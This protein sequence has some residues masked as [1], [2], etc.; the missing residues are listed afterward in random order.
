MVVCL[1]ASGPVLGADLATRLLGTWQCVAGPCPDQ[2]IEFALGERGHR[3]HAW[4][5]RRP[6]VRDGAW[7]LRG[8]RLHI[9]CCAAAGSDWIVMRVD[10]RELVLIDEYSARLATLRRLLGP[11]VAGE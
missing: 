1:G 3:F 4:R 2:R 11:A 9:A 8:E 6:V 5:Q 7:R 10:A